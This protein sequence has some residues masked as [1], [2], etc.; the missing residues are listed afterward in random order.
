[1]KILFV[2]NNQPPTIDGVGDYTYLLAEHLANKDVK[3]VIVCKDIGQSYVG[4]YDQSNLVRIIPFCKKWNV[5]TNIQIL[6][7]ARKEGANFIFIQYVPYGFSK[8]GLP[9]HL[10]TFPF[11]AKPYKVKT[12][13]FFH[14]VAIQ[15]KISRPNWFIRGWLQRVLA[16]L[17]CLST[18]NLFVS[19]Q[20]Y[21]KKFISPSVAGIIPIPSNFNERETHVDVAKSI[22][23][24]KTIQLIAFLNRTPEFLFK[25]IKLLTDSNQTFQL[26]LIGSPTADHVLNAKANIDKYK[27]ENVSIVEDSDEKTLI[28]LMDGADIYIQLEKVESGYGGISAKSGTCAFAMNMALPI[29]TTKGCFTDE[30]IYKDGYNVLFVDYGDPESLKICLE[31][32]M[33]NNQQRLF[34]AN[35]AK[36]TYKTQFSWEVGSKRILSSLELKEYNK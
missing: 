34:L 13:I 30:T 33:A 23:D 16:R 12:A 11:L 25:A 3:S 27:L 15:M 36:N 31:N 32:L 35:N 5:N 14:E 6:K 18:D 24:K 8:L 9:F 22:S 29:I 7:L 19:N 4:R 10:L 2:A 28:H 20:Y 1:M 17:L 26:S 21:F